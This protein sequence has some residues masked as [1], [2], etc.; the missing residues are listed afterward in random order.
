MMF[1]TAYNGY[2]VKFSPFYENRLAVATAQNFGIIG[3]GRQY[4]LETGPEG[5]K[6]IACF[7]T[8]DG[9]YD[10]AWNEENENILVSASGD[11][12]IKVWDL[13]QA[14]QMNPL[15]SFEEH[16]HEVYAVAWNL[17]Q[18]DCFLSASWDDSIKLWNLQSNHSL[19]TFAE[20]TYCIYAVSWNPAHAEIFASASGD[21]TV[22]IW[23][24]RQSQSTLTMAAHE[25]EILACDWNKYNDCVLATGS[26]DKSI[27]LW[28][29]RHPSQPLAVL[30]GH[31][32]A[33]R[34]VVCSPH[35]ENL[36]YSCSYDMSLCL[37]DWAKPP[38]EALLQR[39]G[40]HTEFVVGLDVSSLTEG[41][42]ASTGWDEM[43]YVWRQDMDPSAP[44]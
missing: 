39:W 26:V 10:C 4:V 29:V 15:R 17:V 12:S 6:E 13:S 25:F 41:L 28:D 35:H 8:A 21:N 34:R 36:V 11:G 31:D 23:D 33:V 3:N 9:L 20:H 18:R 7:D 32:Y 16:S 5:V 43:V 2:S 37:W 44:M 42:V 14:P 40:H 38:T 30:Q 24:L 27:K 19:R 1:R 22:K